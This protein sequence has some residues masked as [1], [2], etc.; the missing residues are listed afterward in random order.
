LQ[1][2]IKKKRKLKE[3]KQKIK[4]KKGEWIHTCVAAARSSFGVKRSPHFFFF[5]S[6]LLP[7]EKSLF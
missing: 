4:R 5:P 6:S 3:K 2:E 7:L 1:T